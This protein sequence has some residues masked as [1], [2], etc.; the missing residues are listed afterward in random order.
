MKVWMVVTQS[1][2][3]WIIDGIFSNAKRAKLFAAELRK[4]TPHTIEVQEFEVDAHAGKKARNVFECSLYRKGGSIRAAKT[5]TEIVDPDYVSVS[6]SM[7][8][9]DVRSVISSQ[10]AQALAKEKRKEILK[11]EMH[12]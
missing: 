11:Q 12:G 1:W 4:T 3:E 9:I 10:H 5:V 6:V 7:K 8:S 2:H